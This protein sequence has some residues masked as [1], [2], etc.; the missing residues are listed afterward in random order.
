MHC[1]K[2]THCS[3]LDTNIFI[4]LYLFLSVYSTDGD[5]ADETGGQ[6]QSSKATD[7]VVKR[8]PTGN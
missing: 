2:N 1:T 6:L 5:G 4:I 7:S 3:A 8:P